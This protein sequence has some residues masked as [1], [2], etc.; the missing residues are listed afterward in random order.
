[1]LSLISYGKPMT[2]NTAIQPTPDEV[3][4]QAK[5]TKLGQ[6]ALD[7]LHLGK[8]AEAESDA[9]QALA[10]GKGSTPFAQIALASALAAEGKNQEAIKAYEAWPV[11][12]QYPQEML[13]Y[14]LLLLKSGQYAK[15][16]DAYKQALPYVISPVMVNGRKLLNEESDFIV[17]EPD[18]NKLAAD[19]HIALGFFG[20]DD[21]GSANAANIS[22][23]SYT[24]YREAIKLEPESPIANL[25]YAMTYV[26]SEKRTKQ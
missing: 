22:E 24:E 23:H 5:Q 8:Y 15:A 13:S 14:S 20:A 11:E 7:A 1:M 16:L 25:S 4:S 19:I 17:E 26:V 10:I 3:A 9:R 18:S 12:G 2:K 6:D 21:F